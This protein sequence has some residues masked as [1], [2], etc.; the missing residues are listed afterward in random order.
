[1]VEHHDIVNNEVKVLLVEQGFHVCR[2]A[3]EVR[4]AEVQMSPLPAPEMDCG[5]STMMDFGHVPEEDN[6]PAIG[7][8]AAT[9]SASR[10]VSRNIDVPKRSVPGLLLPLLDSFTD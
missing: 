1:M 4:L 3:Q 2:K 7:T 8:A 5:T 10:S 6:C 9:A